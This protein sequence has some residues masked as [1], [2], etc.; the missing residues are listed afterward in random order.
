M[1]KGSRLL[2]ALPT[3]ARPLDC[4]SSGNRGFGGIREGTDSGGA[5]AG[6][7]GDS[8]ID[9]DSEWHL[10]RYRYEHSV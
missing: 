9:L 6:E 1:L 10:D 8:S 5:G 4:E 7:S 2:A 3:L